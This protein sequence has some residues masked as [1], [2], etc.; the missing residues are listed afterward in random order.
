MQGRVDKIAK[1][2]ALLEQQFIKDTNKT[3]AGESHKGGKCA[4]G[5]SGCWGKGVHVC[6]VV[7]VVEGLS[8]G[9]SIVGHMCSGDGP[10]GAHGGLG[11]WASGSNACS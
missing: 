1:E 5:K 11:G 7:V 6:W 8:C 9:A 3:V 10:E 4:L 2:M